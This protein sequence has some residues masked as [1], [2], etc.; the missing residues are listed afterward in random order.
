MIKIPDVGILIME[1]GTSGIIN[2]IGV[3][4]ILNHNHKIAA[5]LQIK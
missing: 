1:T 5:K 4:N 3:I 2:I